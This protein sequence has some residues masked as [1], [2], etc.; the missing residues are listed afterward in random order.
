MLQD[1]I[2]QVVR[3]FLACEDIPEGLCDTTIVLILK[4]S[5]PEH[6]TY[7]RPISPCNVLYKIAYKVLENR[8]KGLLH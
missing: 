6:L 5:R 2:C 4:V 1:D 7:F 3:S 8:L